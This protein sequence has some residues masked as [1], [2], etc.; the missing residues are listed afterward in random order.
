[1]AVRNIVRIDEEKCDG[2]GQCVSGCAEGAIQI[3]DGKAKL[4]SETYCDGLGACLG[5]CPQGAIT[6]EQREAPEFDEAAA[7][8]HVA[9]QQGQSEAH[10]KEPAGAGGC[11]SSGGCPG[12]R[13]QRWLAGLEKKPQTQEED[14]ASG[15]SQLGHWP[16]QL[17]LVSPGT[18]YF[19][20]AH[21]LLAADCVP[22]AMPDFHGRLL[23]GRAVALGCPKLDDAGAYVEKLAAI[24]RQGRPASL[25][26]VHMEVPCCSGLVRIAE[27]ALAM[28]GVEVP[29]EDVTIGIR[30]EVLL[31]RALAGA[32]A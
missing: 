9:R 12:T 7:I 5:T 19:Q 11:P 2:C 16:V 27:A 32:A 8:A 31:R 25:T 17:H 29:G 6:I 21:L 1:M 14:Q 4:V 30:G 15:P 18:P 24:L 26:V 22:V 20:G 28:A 13:M 23:K 10:V 3:I